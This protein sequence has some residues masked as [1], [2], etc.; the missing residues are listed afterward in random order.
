MTEQDINLVQLLA[1]AY[2]QN[3]RAPKA[4]V[5]LL[6]VDAMMPGQRRVLCALALAQVRSGDPKA[7]LATLDR[8]AMGGGLDAPFYLLRARALAACERR[9]EAAAAMSLCLAMRAHQANAVE[10]LT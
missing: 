1:H 6:A 4:V 8:I 10:A 9:I 5:L 3:A 2:M 7:A